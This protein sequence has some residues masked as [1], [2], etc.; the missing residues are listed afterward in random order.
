V[1]AASWVFAVSPSTAM[2]DE[3]ALHTRGSLIRAVPGRGARPL[4]D[5]LSE[6]PSGF[7]TRGA[8]QVGLER[9]ILAMVCSAREC[10]NLP[11]GVTQAGLMFVGPTPQVIARHG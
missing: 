4:R 9:F 10:G 7:W 8:T 5:S 11:P 2:P 1:P 3:G 6:H